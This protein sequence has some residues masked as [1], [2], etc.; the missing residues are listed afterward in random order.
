MTTDPS[1]LDTLVAKDA[2]RELVLLYS[3]GVD[4]KDGALLRS[5]YTKDATDTHGDTFDGKADA[6]VD[7]LETAFPHMK[8][9]GHHV[10]NHMIS[11]KGEE[12]EGEVY[13]I[14][15]HVIPNREGGFLEDT[16][17]VRY[18]DN[19][20]KEADGRWRFAKRVVT[21][22]M[23]TV[24]PYEPRPETGTLQTEPSYHELKSRLFARGA[25]G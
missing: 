25:R 4:R 2:I 21:Y 12:G 8:Y 16:M 17:C 9:S 13:A 7:F 18:I 22:D 3:R 15:W 20:L 11:V 5:L 23:R 1:A 14:A 10:C 24:R 6:Y 19:Y